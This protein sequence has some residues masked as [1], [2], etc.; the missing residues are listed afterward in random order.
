[1]T[2]NGENTHKQDSYGRCLLPTKLPSLQLA[3]QWGHSGGK[4]AQ[5]RRAGRAAGAAG[6]ACRGHPSP[7]GEPSAR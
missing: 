7:A 3:W 1:M 6:A 4:R 5:R 2:R